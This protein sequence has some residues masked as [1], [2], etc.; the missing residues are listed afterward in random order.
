MQLTYYPHDHHCRDGFG[1]PHTNRCRRD[2]ESLLPGPQKYVESKPFRQLRVVLGHDSTYFWGSRFQYCGPIFLVYGSLSL[3]L[4]PPLFIYIHMYV[5]SPFAY[6]WG[7]GRGIWEGPKPQ[8]IRS[9]LRPPLE[10]PRLRRG[11]CRQVGLGLR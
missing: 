6:F 10:D 1:S 8:P 9:V 3:S 4:S 7:P 5:I 11:G 2:H